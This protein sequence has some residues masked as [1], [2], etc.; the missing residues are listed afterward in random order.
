MNS[1][2]S[3]KSFKVLSRFA[4]RLA[5]I[6]LTLIFTLFVVVTLVGHSVL[7]TVTRDDTYYTFIEESR[8]IERSRGIIAD[9]LVTYALGSGRV[10]ATFLKAYPIQNW[11]RMAEILLP[12][13][14]V[15]AS[16]VNITEATLHWIENPESQTPEFSIDLSPVIMILRSPKGA[17]AVLPLL[18]NVPACPPDVTEITFFGDNLVSCLQEQQDITSIGQQ[19]ANSI[20]DT[21]V[22][23]V[24]FSTLQ[25]DNLL[26]PETTQSLL[27]VKAGLS[28]S[29]VGL[30][31]AVRL[32][33]S[34][35]SLYALLHSSS[36]KNLLTALPI[37]FY[38]AGIF[39]LL[40]LGI[41]KGFLL[42]GLSWVISG[43]FP[44]FNPEVRN[45]IDDFIQALS[46]RII[47]TWL[48]GSILLVTFAFIL[49]ILSFSVGKIRERY[50]Q[51]YQ[52]TRTRRQS[53][54]KH[55]H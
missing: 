34:I 46:G 51:K 15:E 12:V 26:T 40:L 5:S 33:L 24:T 39:S 45:L 20:S 41:Y 18:Q 38:V 49:S 22:E 43:T 44:L 48:F 36:M 17:L 19:I 7:R 10:E 8:F 9:L 35:L 47:S 14:W 55:Y 32:S 3:R 27:K 6:L 16:L 50:T 30:S 52:V 2:S 29:E 23:E 28:A 53:F 4:H 21:L 31:L 11:E 37:P 13:N 54:R 25:Q 1:L 42:F